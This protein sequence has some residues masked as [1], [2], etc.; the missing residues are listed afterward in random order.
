MNYC[1][2]C[3]SEIAQVDTF[4][5]FCGIV[6][7]PSDKQENVEIENDKTVAVNHSDFQD[8]LSENKPEQVVKNDEPEI[9]P[10]ENTES[11]EKNPLDSDFNFSFEPEAK[12]ET[13]NSFAESKPEDSISNS[14]SDFEND[15]K[16]EDENSEPDS[17]VFPE[18]DSN[19]E[20]NDAT[21]IDVPRPQVLENQIGNEPEPENI[22][23]RNVAAQPEPEILELELEA[24]NEKIDSLNDVRQEDG[25]DYVQTISYSNFQRQLA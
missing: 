8:V 15:V 18:K 19:F 6:L 10:K 25:V 21:L 23:E 3:G 2:E 1:H 9:A 13:E 24:S 22:E 17:F 7:K 11:A 4:C 14:F 16:S 20:P 12:N 5:P